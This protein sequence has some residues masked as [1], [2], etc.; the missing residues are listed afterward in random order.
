MLNNSSVLS[1][2]CRW[3]ATNLEFLGNSIVLFAA[4]FATVG[5]KHLSPGTAGFSVS[6]ALQVT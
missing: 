1:F 6:Y 5:R 4:L 3:L 2:S